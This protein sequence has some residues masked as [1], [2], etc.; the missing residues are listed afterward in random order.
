[1]YLTNLVAVLANILDESQVAK[2]SILL[3]GWP[4]Q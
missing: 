3:I 2:Q 4:I 1:M